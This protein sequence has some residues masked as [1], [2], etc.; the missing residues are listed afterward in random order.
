MKCMTFILTVNRER[1]KGERKEREREWNKI[2][3]IKKSRIRTIIHRDKKIKGV[4]M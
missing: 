1:E 2:C 4:I 3:L